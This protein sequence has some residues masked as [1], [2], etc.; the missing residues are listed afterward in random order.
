M[1]YGAITLD[2]SIFDRYKCRLETGMLAELH[3]F[4]GKPTGLVLSEIV[5]REVGA[6]LKKIIT[7]SVR[8]VDG[9]LKACEGDLVVS[10]ETIKAARKML[11]PKVEIRDI[12]L[13]RVQ[14]YLDAT[15]GTVVGV[16]DH[17]SLQ[18]VVVKY[19]AH[20]APFS[21]SGKK[22]NEFPDALALLSL[23]GWAK[24][25]NTKILAV[26]M[27]GDWSRF[28]EKSEHIDVVTDLAKAL[29][30]FQPDNTAFR[31]CG[32]F[33]EL[34]SRESAHPLSE[35][36]FE[37]VSDEIS[38]ISPFGICDSP[39][40]AEGEYVQLTVDEIEIVEDDEIV[41]VQ[42]QEHRLAVKARF[43]TSII[44]ESSFEFSVKDS[45]DKDYV[46]M[47]S[48]EASV[49][50]ELCVDALIELVGDFAGDPREIE[51][52]NVQLLTDIND[53]DFGYLEPAWMHEP[54]A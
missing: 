13:S 22:K 52:D 44:A 42:A 21:E 4:K 33:H 17:T 28:A 53:I 14:A 24:S 23:E 39:F 50:I 47:G 54:D 18:A 3:Q 37:M 27:D 48:S 32:N 49:E 8:Q 26:S 2:T 43:L 36:I 1:S 5:I 16:E 40:M 38:A 6:H 10:E 46:S 15:G 31:F 30:L 9:A 12:V 41:P 7:D 51:V 34:L 45:I 19:F 25:Q 11:V 20:E 35:Q 29:E